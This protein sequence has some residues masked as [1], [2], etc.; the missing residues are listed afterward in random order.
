MSSPALFCL[1]ALEIYRNGLPYCL[2]IKQLSG[3]FEQVGTNTEYVIHPEEI[4]ADN[5]PM[6]IVDTRDLPPPAI[7]EK[8]KQ[9]LSGHGRTLKKT[10]AGDTSGGFRK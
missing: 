5:F 8:M 10:D 9:I 3:F 2:E 1:S 6:L 4:L 7:L